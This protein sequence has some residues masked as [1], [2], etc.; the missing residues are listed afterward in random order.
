MHMSIGI[1]VKAQN[2]E[3]AK[4][5]IEGALDYLVGD[6]R[7][8][9]YSGDVIE[10][11]KYLPEKGKGKELVNERLEN[12][13]AEFMDHIKVVREALKKCS[14]K[15]LYEKD[16]GNRMFRWH[17]YHIGEYGGTSCWLYSEW[18]SGLRNFQEFNDSLEEL[19][20]GENY[21]IVV[22]DVHC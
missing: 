11:E 17:C 6:G 20:E 5:N 9:D 16:F 2:S 14:D 15:E 10:V 3:D 8:F 19:G 21:Y 12:N 13:K 1:M 18:G 4:G 22:V 7:P